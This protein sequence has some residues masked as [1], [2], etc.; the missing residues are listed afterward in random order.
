MTFEIDKRIHAVNLE[1]GVVEAALA[2]QFP[3][4][5]VLNS[6]TGYVTEPLSLRAGPSFMASQVTEALPGE[7]LEELDSGTDG[8]HSDGNW[9][10]V[11]TLH[12][13][14][15][16]YAWLHGGGLSGTAPLRPVLVQMPRTHLFAAPSIRAS[17][18]ALL[19]HGAALQTLDPEPVQ[20]GDY[21]WWQVAY[22][23][24][25]AYL[26][27]AAAQ[28]P[29][30]DR[31]AFIQGYLHT[32][33]VWGGRT[34]WGLDCSG[35]AQLYAGKDQQGRSRLPRD[36][37]QQQAATHPV[38]APEAGD[39]AFFPGHVGI[40]LDERRM[41]H[42]NATHMAVSIETL[43]EGGYG[44]R[45]QAEVTGYGRLREQA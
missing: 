41:I 37:D 32:P 24:Q 34:A 43:G 4:L 31:L 9:A 44:R 15:L 19:G 29:G 33:Y 39:L 17:I 13:G 45:L 14:Y 40:M 18:L 36:A 8:G 7:V 12:D 20:H 21:H 2:R 23:G 16:G 25:E 27:A 5:R 3:G 22:G 38:A 42:A 35:L 30:P 6:R 28:H 10:W 11:R 1:R 26:H